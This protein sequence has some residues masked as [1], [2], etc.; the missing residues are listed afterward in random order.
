M[1]FALKMRQW[2]QSDMLESKICCQG[3]STKIL[4]RLYWNIHPI[5]HLATLWILLSIAAQK[6]AT[7]VQANAK[8]TYLHSQ[9]DPNEIF[10]ITIP[11]GY[12]QFYQLP[13]NLQHLP[14]KGLACHMWQPLYSSQQGAYRFYR[15]LL[16]TLTTVGFTVSNADKALFYKFE[17]EALYII[18]AHNQWLY[19]CFKFW[20]IC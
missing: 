15:F 13:S 9:N 3:F 19:H 4:H 6:N 16:E 8:N 11:E 1:G 18:L 12:L 2:R 7:I 5:I 10:Y 17:S 14:M 20:P